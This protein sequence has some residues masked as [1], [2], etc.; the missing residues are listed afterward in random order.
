M[1]RII[2]F[3]QVLIVFLS[4][5]HVAKNENSKL[6]LSSIEEGKLLLFFL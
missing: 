6:L 1:A 3:V 2:K 5:F 4:L